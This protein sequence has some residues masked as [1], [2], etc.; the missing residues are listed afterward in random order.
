MSMAP[1]VRTTNGTYVD[2]GVVGVSGPIASHRCVSARGKHR[3][4]GGGGGRRMQRFERLHAVTAQQ[5]QHF[6]R[7]PSGFPREIAPVK[8]RGRDPEH[9]ARIAGG[10]SL[11]PKQAPTVIVTERRERSV[12]PSDCEEK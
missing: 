10:A 7:E 5:P 12:G 9:T 2:D 1:A 11:Q 4:W 3:R 8:L 6:R